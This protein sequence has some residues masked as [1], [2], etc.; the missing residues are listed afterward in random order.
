MGQS[1]ADSTLSRYAPHWRRFTLWCSRFGV[2]ALPAKPLHIAMFLAQTLQYALEQSLAYGVVKASSAA[3]FQAHS[4]AGFRNTRTDHPVVKAIRS[5]AMRRLGLHPKRRKEPVSLQLCMQCARRLSTPGESLFHHQLAAYIMVC[6]AGF[7][8]YNDAANIFVD[9]I[10]FYDTHMEVFIEKRKTLQFRQGDVICIARG[11]SEVCPV[12]LLESFFDRAG[13]WGRH[14]PAFQQATYLRSSRFYLW[15][16]IEAWHYTQA[17]RLTLEALAFTAG[18]PQS[19]FTR[20]FGLQSLRSG[21]ASHVAAHGVRD[22][23][24]QMHGGWADVRSMLR[25][26]KRPLAN[27][28]RPTTVMGY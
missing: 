14:V 8:R 13:L 2:R 9:D 23:I 12:R 20:S 18:V 11:T 3:I 4:L 22:H 16:S 24:F 7:L 5:A 6:F 25:Y 28:L 21:G 15:G 17:R 1:R 27:R 26:I 10:K 19:V